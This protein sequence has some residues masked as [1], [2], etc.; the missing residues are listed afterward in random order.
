MIENWYDHERCTMNTGE[1]IDAALA[2]QA[3]YND[4]KLGSAAASA[5]LQQAQQT[6]TDANQALHDDLEQNG[7]AVTIS[8]DTPPVVTLYEAADP[9][10]YSATVIRI[11]A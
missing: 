7:P 3:D 8:D 2:A 1:L 4:A 9:D 11:A 6:L 5:R 10:T